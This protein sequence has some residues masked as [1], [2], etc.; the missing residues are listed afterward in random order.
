MSAVCPYRC[1]GMIARVTGVIDSAS[2]SGS[3]V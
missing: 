2:F 1:T 3:I